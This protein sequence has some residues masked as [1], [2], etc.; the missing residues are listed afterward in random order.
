MKNVLI[1]LLCLFATVGLIVSC[2]TNTQ[3]ENTIAGAA[4][5][6]VAGGL[7]GSLATGAGSG[8]VIAAGAV[9]GG[10]VGGLVGHSMDSSDKANV[11]SAM[12]NPTNKPTHWRNAKKHTT[13]TVT[14]IGPVMSYKGSSHCRKFN[15][16][17]TV[18]GKTKQQD[19]VACLQSDGNWVAV[20]A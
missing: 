8:W 7:L 9:V 18:N 3:K 19:G 11:N 4:T 12:Q 6:A 2:S 16:I 10:I 15:S 13:Y 14:P 5:G 1:K 17:T 20:K